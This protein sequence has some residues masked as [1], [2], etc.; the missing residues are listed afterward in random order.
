M[1][2]RQSSI[3]NRKLKAFTLIELL[4]VIAIISL[5]VSILLPSLSRAKEL[6]RR[7]VCSGNMRQLGLAFVMY[8]NDGAGYFPLIREQGPDPLTGV[9]ADKLYIACA[10]DAAVFHC[11]SAS[12]RTYSPNEANGAFAIA[13][14][15]EWW[16]GGM[17]TDARASY[18]ITQIDRPA[19]MVLL[20]ESVGK[21]PGDSIYHHGYGVHNT[22][23]T[24]WCL[25]DD[26]RHAGVSNILCVD[27]HVSPYSLDDALY[28]G[29]LIWVSTKPG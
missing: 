26:T 1:I 17:P 4:V 29:E 9:W 8:T 28:G 12:D 10:N 16:I 5:L 20:G 18:K 14:G 13:Y 7:V 2:N 6:A 25:P 19:E 21:D 15:M 24:P 27:G 3:E 22:E 23:S 11:P